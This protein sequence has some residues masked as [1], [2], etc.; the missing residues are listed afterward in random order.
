[1]S[2]EISR[3]METRL[4]DEARRQGISVDGVDPT[5]VSP[6]AILQLEHSFLI[7]STKA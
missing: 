3:E 6:A 7:H 2:V 5:V 4:A 1:M